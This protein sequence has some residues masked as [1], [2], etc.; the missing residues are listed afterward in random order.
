MD[1]YTL[2]RIIDNKVAILLL[3]DDETVQRDV[4]VEQ[5]PKVSE[6]DILEVTFNEDNTVKYATVLKKETE[7][8]R[9][10]AEQLLK[11]ILNKNK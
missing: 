7:D 8:T 11:K 2:D 1:K 10:Q 6:G 3:M 5:L 4:S 9:E